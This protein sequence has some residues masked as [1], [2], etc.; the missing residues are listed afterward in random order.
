MESGIG[1]IFLILINNYGLIGA[2]LII[3][4]ILAIFYGLITGFKYLTQSIFK[5]IEHHKRINLKKHPFFDDLD[6]LINHKLKEVKTP[7]VIRK[8]IYIDIMTIRLDSIKK[9]FYNLIQQDVSELSA[10]QL[11]HKVLLALDDANTA[12][13][14]G[15]VSKGVPIFVLD[16]MNE[17]RKMIN[18]LYYNAI[19]GYC[20][21]NY[22]YSNNNERMYAI[23]QMIGVYV[24]CYMNVLQ[25][26][27]AQFNGDI[28][29]LVYK[30]IS[31]I[32]CVSCVHEQ[33]L[34]ELKQEIKKDSKKIQGN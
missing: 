4:L 10:K 31:C 20:Y 11:Y 21:N 2:V 3:A 23:L 26:N 25:E 34:A 7:C 24:E 5:K 17:K 15:A 13:I 18:K 14:T 28:K 32:D 33:Y 6:F 29:H 16:S 12:A 1:Q 27:L 22:I 8:Q 9:T 30:G 19:K